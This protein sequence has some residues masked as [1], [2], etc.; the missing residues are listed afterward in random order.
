MK[1]PCKQ[2]TNFMD[3]GLTGEV[4]QIDQELGGTGLCLLAAMAQEDQSTFTSTQDD[5]GGDV[6]GDIVCGDAVE[7]DV[8]GA[9]EGDVDDAVEGDGGDCVDNYYHHQFF[10]VNDDFVEKVQDA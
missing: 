5:C 3:M 6:D 9:V 4:L 1:L 2:P 7:G 10:K 8:D